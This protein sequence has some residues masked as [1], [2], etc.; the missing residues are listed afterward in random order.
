MATRGAKPKSTAAH[1]LEGT[2]HPTRHGRRRAVKMPTGRGLREPP[3]HLTALQK[4]LWR[5]VIADAPL[6]VL[7]RIDQAT[8]AAYVMAY[9]RLI[10]A[11][12][13]QQKHER[14]CSEQTPP[15]DPLLFE[16]KSGNVIQSPY[17]GMINRA[18]DKI[19]K[20]AGEMGFTPVSRIRLS[21]ASGDALDI[22]SA[23]SAADLAAG[24]EMD[25]VIAR[26]P[27]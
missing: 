24:D 16:T 18:T 9:A 25:A 6:D 27:H 2:F 14:W 15:Q 8:I 21:A 19:S 5:E 22:P 17:I 23:S 13:A 26:R 12:L 10:E 1:A 20:L 4:E 3:S 11:N 7:A